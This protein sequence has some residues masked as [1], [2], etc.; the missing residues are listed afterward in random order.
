MLAQPATVIAAAL[1][2]NITTTDKRE[3]RS[4]ARHYGV[5]ENQ[6]QRAVNAVG[7]SRFRV[8][9]WLKYQGLLIA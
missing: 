5:S 8:E 9:G 7:D 4:W 2:Q 6:L 3:L 1:P